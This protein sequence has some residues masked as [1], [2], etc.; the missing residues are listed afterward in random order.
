MGGAAALDRIR[1]LR[2]E[3]IGRYR[4]PAGEMI[5]VPTTSS[6]LFPDR[7]L[8][9]VSLSVGKMTTLISGKNA[10]LIIARRS[11][12]LPESEKFNVEDRILRNPVVLLRKRHDPFFEAVP[13]NSGDVNGRRVDWVR[14][15]LGQQ[16]V[17]WAALDAETGLICRIRYR[18]RAPEGETGAEIEATYS[19]YRTVKGLR[20]PFAVEV[21]VSGKSEFRAE[22]RSLLVDEGVSAAIFEPPAAG[23]GG[24]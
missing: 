24:P 18:E 16:K 1:S 13:G 11:T 23:W 20:Y 14:M 9:E 17:T 15:Q 3:S 19:D 7:Y 2:V 22:T 21:T 5:E 4:M 6:L 10:Y 8:H 12:P